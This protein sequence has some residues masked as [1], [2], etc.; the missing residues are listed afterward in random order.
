MIFVCV[1]ARVGARVYV[2]ARVFEKKARVGAG[3]GREGAR[4]SSRGR[5]SGQGAGAD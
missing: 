1:C 2:S 4:V 5:P 3:V